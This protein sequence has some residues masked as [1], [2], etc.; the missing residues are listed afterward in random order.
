[1]QKINIIL[2]PLKVREIE[3]SRYKSEE[4]VALSLYV[5][6]R[7]NADQQVYASLTCKIHLVK[8]LRANLLIDNDIILPE[9]FIID[10]KKRSV[11]IRSCKVTVPINI[12]QKGQFFIRKLLISQDIVVLPHLEVI[13]S[14]IPLPL[15]DDQNF[16]FYP[17]AQTN[18]TLFIHLV[19]YQISKILVKN[20][21]SQMLYV[22]RR[23]KLGHLI[24]IAYK[25]YFLA[26]THSIR[27]AAIFSPLL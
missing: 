9:G 3:A 13:V 19:D 6:G 8:D 20:T 1:M 4:F 7:D 2:T 26:D 21:S 23:Y 5:P 25:N 16:L 15:P 22:L 27:S 10:I 17:F 14:L 24:N 18:L 12:R 11:L